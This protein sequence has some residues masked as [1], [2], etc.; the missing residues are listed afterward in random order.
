MTKITQSDDCFYPDDPDFPC[1]AENLLEMPASG[2]RVVLITH[3]R[4]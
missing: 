4:F 2:D 1:N 3:G